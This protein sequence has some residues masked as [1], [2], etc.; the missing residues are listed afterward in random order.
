MA[1][2]PAAEPFADLPVPVPAG[3]LDVVCL[4]PIQH[5]LE[6]EGLYGLLETLRERAPRSEITLHVRSAI[7]DPVP[8]Q[9]LPVDRME[10]L[11]EW[12]GRGDLTAALRRL[13]ALR[14]A[15]GSYVL[16]APPAAWRRLVPGGV[17]VTATAGLDFHTVP[18][19][20]GDCVV[21]TA[22]FAG[23]I[24]RESPRWAA[25]PQAP[26]GPLTVDGAPRILIHQARFHVGDTLWLTPLLREVRRRFRGAEI[27]LVAPACARELLV[28]NL[29]V[30]DLQCYDPRDG[31]E[32][33][34]RVLAALA[35]RPFDAAI[36]AFARRPESRWLAEAAAVW[37]VPYRVG[38]E[39][40]DPAHGDG[41]SWAPLTHEG[42]FFWGSMASPRMLLHGLDPLLRPEPL[43]HRYRGDR[44]AELH[45]PEAARP[46]AA[47]VLESCG[48]GRDPF[49]VLCPGGGSSRRWPAESFARLAL[50]L[51]GHF[52]L[53]VLVEG[54]PGEEGVLAEVAG[55][56]AQGRAWRSV[57]VRSDPLDVLAV[58]LERSRLLVAN[59]SGAIHLAEAVA[60]PT[61]YFAQREKLAHSHPRTSACWALYDDVGNDPAAIT[62]EQAL[63]AVRRMVRSG[64]IRGLAS[65]S[66]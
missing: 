2:S 9:V 42:R 55:R 46:R 25:A 63:G 41:A 43:E 15:D 54:G 12:R 56:V 64:L 11:G 13:A 24:R 62:V 28:G 58:L 8:F 22:L 59:D 35:G 53:H 16:I 34:R 1:R 48:F 33:R 32:G 26:S 6:Y 60:A 57:A 31:E 27:T 30:N 65:H 5:I 14:G 50:L 39:Y 45:V 38:L 20:S 7:R 40:H 19:R 17:R 61:L 51:T 3:A 10:R 21:S 29:R 44:R 37:G 52:G 18:S 66:V 49:A 47:E 23:A 4:R 36:F